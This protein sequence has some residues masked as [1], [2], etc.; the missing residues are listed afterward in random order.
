M[1]S[2]FLTFLAA[3]AALCLMVLVW[4][5][6]DRLANKTLGERN[7]CCHS[8]DNE[9]DNDNTGGCCGKHASCPV[10]DEDKPDDDCQDQKK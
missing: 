9:A 4:V 7:R 2:T 5:A 1:F 8:L 10:A 3:I 6:I